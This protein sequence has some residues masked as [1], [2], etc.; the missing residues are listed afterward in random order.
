MEDIFNRADRRLIVSCFSSSI[1]RLQTIMD[2]SAEFGRKV[3]LV[4]RSMMS[5]TE[6]AHSLG[7]I[8]IPDGLL[9]RTQDIMQTP[10]HKLT[11]LISGT[12]GEPMSALSRVAVDNHK[13]ISVERGDTVVLSS[14][15]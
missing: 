14:R 6:I 1:H 2:L 3:A 11:A 8:S 12:Q 4:G 5:A 13:H 9:I 15:I 10:P 7:L